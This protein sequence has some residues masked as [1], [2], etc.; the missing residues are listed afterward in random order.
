ML[1]SQHLLLAYKML[2]S[3]C[4]LLEKVKIL[5]ACKEKC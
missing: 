3:F 4:L 2:L 5:Q 1:E